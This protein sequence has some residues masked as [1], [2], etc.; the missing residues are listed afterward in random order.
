MGRQAEEAGPLWRQRFE[1]VH[2]GEEGK[3]RE[4]GYGDCDGHKGIVK[5]W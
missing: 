2:E 5:S 3:E 4:D 1:V